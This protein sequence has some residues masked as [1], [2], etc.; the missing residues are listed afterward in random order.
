[1]QDNRSSDGFA[2]RTAFFYAVSCVLIG[3]HLP[4]FP[5]WLQAKGFDAGQ[6]GAILS[7]T[8]MLRVI[9]VPLATGAADRFDLR[10][11][12]FITSVATALGVVGLGLAGPLWLI[13]ALTLFTAFANTPAMATA[14]PRNHRR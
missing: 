4:F 2:L 3:I 12:I 6:V 8:A 9:S 14:T 1:M 11:V 13:V 7:A 10:S 5:V